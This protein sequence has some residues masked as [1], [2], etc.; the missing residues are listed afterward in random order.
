MKDQTDVLIAG[1]GPTGLTLAS[2]LMRHGLTV[3]IVDEADA[4]SPWSKAIAVHARTLEILRSMG[5]ADA[6][7][8]KGQKIRGATMWSGGAAIVRADFDELETA[9][10]YVLSLPQS[11]TEAVLADAVARHGGAVERST[12]LVSFRQD[13]TG[14]TATLS[15][16]GATEAVRAAWLVG[17]DGA[18]SVVRKAL[19]M[20]FE[21][22]TYEDVFL[23]ADV[24]IAWDTRDDRIA[25]YFAD[26]GLVACFPMRDGRWRV[27]ATAPDGDDKAAAPTLDEMQTVFARR[28]GAGAALSD[29]AWSSRFHIHCRQVAEYRDDRVM[30]AGDAAHIHSPAGGQ[31]MNTGIQDAHNLAWKLA[32]VHKGL[33]RDRLLATYH[34]ERHAVGEAVLRG[35]DVATRVG[36][37]KNAVIKGAR[38][39]AARLLSSLEVVQQRVAREVA[40]LSVGYERSALSREDHT[41]MLQARIG[42]AAGAE[43]PTITA[44]RWFDSAVAAGQRAKDGRVTRAGES[45]TRSL[46][47]ALDTRRWNLLLFDGRSA[48][49]EGYQRFAS[50][51]SAVTAR[52]PEAV[53]VSV[54]TPRATRPSELP[55]SLPVLLDP[56]GELERAYGAVSECVY[57][58]RPD[59]YVGYRSQPADEAKVMAYLRPFL[60]PAP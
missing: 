37:V 48:S 1:A 26:D 41:S 58:L 53:E 23:L 12:R 20:P 21:G 43:T 7:I 14:V 33:A 3:R 60:R 29:M 22:S 2:E 6:L 52:Y 39:Q 16:G 59:L 49:A 42:T 17:C 34:D 44:I 56:D 28:T 9:Y 25:A 51:A 32:H 10:P 15:K 54:V 27:I 46:L 5:V 45:G 38:D 19:D 35:T 47:D 57:L 24:K 50:I 30:L 4:P 18:R 13:G 8:E 31:G 36:T 40:E 11:E 55:E